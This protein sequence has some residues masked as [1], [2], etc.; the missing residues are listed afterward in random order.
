MATSRNPQNSRKRT[1]GSSKNT[2]RSTTR[3]STG[4]RASSSRSRSSS[5][6]GRSSSG[7]SF[8]TQHQIRTLVLLAVCVLLFVCNFG[9]LGTIG[10]AISN[11]MFGIFGLLA[12]VVPAIIFICAMFAYSQAGNGHM[13]AKMWESLGLVLLL[14]MVFDLMAGRTQDYVSYNLIT[15][16]RDCAAAHNGGGIIAGSLTYLLYHTLSIAGTVIVLLLLAFLLAVVLTDGALLA[17][18]RQGGSAMRERA[19]QS[20]ENYRAGSEE[21][22]RR[23][24][25]RRAYEEE[26]RLRNEERR[27]REA[28]EREE[29]RAREQE[30]RELRRQQ[31]EDEKILRMDRKAVGVTDDLDLKADQHAT[32]EE[33]SA[34]SPTTEANGQEN[35]FIPEADPKDDIHE[36]I[37]NGDAD[38]DIHGFET[39]SSNPENRNGAA[40]EGQGE[41]LREYEFENRQQKTGLPQ[42]LPTAHG[43]TFSGLGFEGDEEESIEKPQQEANTIQDDGQAEQV[44][45]FSPLP[46]ARFET[47]ATTVTSDID[48]EFDAQAQRLSEKLQAGETM[49]IPVSAV[50]LH[51]NGNDEYAEG[52]EPVNE[53]AGGTPMEYNDGY[54]VHTQA[55]LSPKNSSQNGTSRATPVTG[56]GAS[57][58]G[59]AGNSASAQP[60]VKAVQ[61]KMNLHRAY[62]KPKLDFLKPGEKTRTS[63]AAKQEL[64]ATANKLETTLKS[65]GINAKVTDISQGPSV[66]RY[67]LQP[68]VGVKVSR[69]VNL[70]DDLKMNLAATDIR[71]EAPI[72]GKPAVGIEVPNKENTTVS[73]RDLLESKEFKEFG[74]KLA[75]AV[76][77]DIAG[78]TVVADIAKMPHLLIAGATGSGKSV[79]IN[80]LILSILYNANPE[81]VQLIMVDPKVVELSVYNGIPHLMIPVVTDP[82]KAAAALNWGVQEMTKRY[83]LFADA[84]VRDLKGYNEYLKVNAADDGTVSPLPQIVIIVDELADLMMV[85]KSEVED[86]IC[87]LAQ[88]AR[89]AGIH[90]I[91]A[92]QRPSVDVITGLIKA[93]MPSRIAFAVSSG[94]DSRTILDMNGAEKLLGKG[95]M[96]FY[97]QNYS[98]PVRVQGAFVSDGEI[99]KITDFLK[100]QGIESAYSHEVM[101]S[102]EK[103]DNSADGGKGSSDSNNDNGN[104]PLFEDA[105]RLI[106]EQQ[107]A[108]IG[109]LQR[110]FKIGF[111]RAA[112]IMDQ[113]CEAGVVGKEEGT[114]PR[115]ILMSLEEF[116]QVFGNE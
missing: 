36:I 27:A 30:E 42:D 90:L 18:I 56:F 98:K 60:P 55:H 116:N 103:A 32:A 83:K 81:E 23:R 93:N 31:E 10:N 28:Q 74:S 104:D 49:G 65:F 97:P 34:S 43:I 17:G 79:C 86:A 11:V 84:G 94:I 16:F 72:P 38:Q 40:F 9:L 8:E 105:G 58:A 92:T 51:I 85:S 3:K 53:F 80:T 22:N 62:K 89:A 15:I 77:K 75:F 29:R 70:A 41:E 67:E 64:K 39:S 46:E 110:R 2:T 66:T 5:G 54:A 113:L 21:R 108:S 78:K 25:E 87:R 35:V 100:N 109:Y 61:M 68:E 95:D 4:S 115:T 71:I 33:E 101:S 7:M 59:A 45:E 102:I 69:I 82:K 106:I 14:G 48:P 63:E 37:W 13:I 111:N 76:G 57:G 44:T 50:N 107:K 20:A 99:Q 96:L 12:Y 112:R 19:E 114:K 47:K 52:N 1:S 73:L 26:R 88:L 24:E 91:L 6:S